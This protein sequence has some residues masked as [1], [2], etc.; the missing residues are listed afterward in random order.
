MSRLWRE[1]IGDNPFLQRDLRRWGRRGYAWKALLRCAGWPALVLMAAYALYQLAPP[2]LHRLFDRPFGLAL[3][4]V[5]ALVHYWVRRSIA[6]GRV[7]LVDEAVAGR[8]DFIR[9][10]PLGRRELIAKIGISR[11]AI[12]LL[13]VM[14][15]LA[16]FALLLLF[17]GVRAEDLLALSGLQMMLLFHP[18]DASEVRAAL[19]PEGPG[20]LQQVAR[21]QQTPDSAAAAGGGC[22]AAFGMLL[23]ATFALRLLRGS[24]DPWRLRLAALVGPGLASLFPLSVAAVAAR[25][26]WAP[27]PFYGWLLSPGWPLALGWGLDRVCRVVGGAEALARSADLKELPG[28]RKVTTLPDETGRPE[29]QRTLRILRTVL[30]ALA[31]LGLTGFCW[32][33][34][35]VSGSLGRLVES[36]SPSG[37]IAALL[38]VL[39]GP[40]ALFCWDM[41]PSSVVRSR[42]GLW[43]PFL[44]AL[45]T[46][47]RALGWAALM[48]LAASAL[49]ATAPWPEPAEALILLILLAASAATFNL[50]LRVWQGSL[51]AQEEDKPAG[52][53][54]GFF[55]V[56][57]GFAVY[58]GP[59][60]LLLGGAPYAGWHTLAACSPV[61]ALLRLLPGLWRAPSPLPLAECLVLPAVVGLASLRL[62]PRRPATVP[63]APAEQQPTDPLYVRLAAAAARWDNPLFMVAVRRLARRRGSLTK[64]VLRAPLWAFGLSACLMGLMLAGSISRRG[65]AVYV[66]SLSR[67]V[68][69]S[70]IERGGVFALLAAGGVLLVTSFSIGIALSSSVTAEIVVAGTQR[71][72]PFLLISP[73]A[74]R[75]IVL[76]ML[77]DGAP[78]VVPMVA[79]GVTASLGWIVLA[80]L[81]QA[82]GWWLGAWLLA[83]AIGLT[84][85]LHGAFASFQVWSPRR[86]RSRVIAVL[87]GIGIWVALPQV[88][89]QLMRSGAGLPA[90]L[91]RA[92]ASDW[93][94]VSLAV[95][96]LALAVAL[97]LLPLSFRRAVR[98]VRARRIAGEEP[99][100]PAGRA[101]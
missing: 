35:V 76:G 75:E 38:I 12:G 50:G 55:P 91:E 48:A 92:I 87:V 39:G 1:W 15:P 83:V 60:G 47:A 65:P 10:L 16:I 85:V 33:P 100:G 96:A 27:Q 79:G 44:E 13:P 70:A 43:L 21:A 45:K 54:R 22:M 32:Q 73:L 78:A 20:D 2:H 8:L 28:G 11:A 3:F 67:T 84:L 24:L 57:L 51:P 17:H 89:F 19:A 99:A 34:L 98:A 9:L 94:L 71:R 97:L 82:P 90:P 68:G 72:L 69:S 63:A 74:D 95:A 25:L 7:S 101:P 26:L 53:R 56:L 52:R 42:P 4:S 49:G 30:K 14:A 36:A 64:R 37:S 23:T 6:S 62:S 29:E 77:A 31:I 88:A 46:A 58:L 80:I 61:Y 66:Q 59:V 93:P 18:P 86:R 81:G 41:V 5:V 40:P